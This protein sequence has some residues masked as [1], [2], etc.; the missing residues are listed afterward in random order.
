MQRK[1][2]GEIEWLEFDLLQE[3]PKLRHGVFLRHGGV[4]KPPYGPLNLRHGHGDEDRH[5]QTNL[6]RVQMILG[7]DR[8]VHATQV[9][10][11]HL[12][13]VDSA[14][15][16]DI[17]MCDGLFTSTPHI[18]LL[19]KHADCQAAIFY[20][21]LNHA[22]ACVHSG[23]K[24]S[25]QN[26]YSHT[27]AALQKR[28]GSRPEELLVGISPSLGPTAAGFVNYQTELPHTFWEY[29]VSLN[30]FNFWE[31]SRQQLIEAGVLAGHIE[32][33]EIC[34]YTESDDYFSYRREGVT[35]RHGT[36]VALLV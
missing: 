18:G 29:R 9:H 19:I 3:V 23:W 20:D 28:Y 15:L 33:A 36:A 24:G 10:G 8:L 31:I 27:V 32:I 14:D 35:G 25:V 4:S 22:A 6:E 1:S 26:I 11:T 16:T 13:E 21:P 30:H 5:V 34:N 7:A 2:H 12:V 17:P